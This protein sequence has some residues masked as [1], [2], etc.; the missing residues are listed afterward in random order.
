MAGVSTMTRVSC[1]CI[2]TSVVATVHLV[3]CIRCVSDMSAPMLR[4]LLRLLSSMMMHCSVV[5]MMRDV[6]VGMFFFLSHGHILIFSPPPWEGM[7][8]DVL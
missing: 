2:V 7:T 5:C 6:L 8:M 4:N 1:V 3:L